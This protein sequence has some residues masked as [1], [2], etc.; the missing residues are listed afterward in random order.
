MGF[1]A[2]AIDNGLF[3]KS[4]THQGLQADFW[5]LKNLI[6]FLLNK[7]SRSLASLTPKTQKPKTKGQGRGVK[8]PRTQLQ[9]LALPPLNKPTHRNGRRPAARG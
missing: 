3:R 8:C 7:R 1:S 2:T 6:C 5:G 9:E 4:Q